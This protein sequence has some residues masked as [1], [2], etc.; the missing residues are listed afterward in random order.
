VEGGGFNTV[1]SGY[2]APNPGWEGE[3]ESEIVPGTYTVRF[4][5]RT[6]Y[7]SNTEG[8]SGLMTDIFWQ[9][10]ATVNSKEIFK[11]SGT[12]TMRN[13][14][15]YVPGSTGPD[16][17]D[18]FAFDPFEVIKKSSSKLPAGR[19]DPIERVPSGSQEDTTERV[20]PV[21]LPMSPRSSSP[22]PTYRHPREHG[23]P[24]RTT[25]LGALDSRSSR[26]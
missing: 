23:D 5:Y 3:A 20:P 6:L 2:R 26:E 18:L 14:D 22:C 11:A 7:D 4:H 17:V 16:W 13:P 19:E 9:C 21:V 12:I 24:A 1:L 10:R 25:D 8:P 15:N